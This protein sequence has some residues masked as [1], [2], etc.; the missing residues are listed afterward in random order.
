MSSARVMGKR[1]PLVFLGIVVLGACAGPDAAAGDSQDAVDIT[2]SATVEP[3]AVITARDAGVAADI[4]SSGTVDGFETFCNG[5]SD[6]N[7]A[8]VAIPG[9]EAEVDFQALCEDNGVEYVEVPIGLDALSLIRHDDN[10]DVQDLSREELSMIWAPDSDVS[11]WS[12]VRPEWPDEEIS[13]YGRDDGSGTYAVFTEEINGAVGAIRADYDSTDDL[14]ELAG[15]V[16]DDPMS[17]AFTGVG[18]Y[19]SAPEDVRNAITTVDVEG[20]S[21]S[22]ENTLTGSYPLARE[23]YLYV[24]VDALRAHPA[25]EEFVAHLLQNGRNIVPRAFFY[26]LDE[27]VY[28][29]ALL[30]LEEHA[31][32]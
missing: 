9:P 31:S 3:I 20:V 12:D 18:N 25:V 24:S 29:E 23:L 2:G 14:D 7:N 32:S 10:S 17:L 22:L 21:P 1:L 28:E 8:S 15:W 19:L 6:I 16:A 27:S 30:R 13:L 26:P 11:T 4:S 5:N